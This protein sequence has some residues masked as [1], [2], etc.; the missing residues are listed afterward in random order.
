[1]CFFT[2]I[3]DLK[4]QS[5]PVCPDT[6]FHERQR[7][8]TSPTTN[9]PATSSRSSLRPN[10]LQAGRVP[11]VGNTWLPR[12]ASFPVAGRAYSRWRGD[13]VV[14][15]L[16]PKQSDEKLSASREKELKPAVLALFTRDAG[17]TK[18]GS[19]C[20]ATSSALPPARTERGPPL[21]DAELGG[22]NGTASPAA[23]R[24]F[25]ALP[26]K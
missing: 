1:M 22:G 7:C 12:V 19:T 8:T 18:T 25:D 3:R 13:P 6:V 11:L 4:A 9:G 16:F 14:V 24:L 20:S 17:S 23:S 2:R 15:S 5:T 26:N 21:L 10:H